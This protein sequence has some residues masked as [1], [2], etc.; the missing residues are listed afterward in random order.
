MKIMNAIGKVVCEWV[1]GNKE[2]I[3]CWLNAAFA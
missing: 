1:M 3:K 2:L